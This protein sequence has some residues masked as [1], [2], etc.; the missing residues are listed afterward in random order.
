MTISELYEKQ[1]QLNQREEEVER[2]EQELADIEFAKLPKERQLE[3]ELWRGLRTPIKGYKI[4]YIGDRINRIH[5]D[6]CYH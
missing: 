4:E 6:T 1:K 2:R 5:K 3:I